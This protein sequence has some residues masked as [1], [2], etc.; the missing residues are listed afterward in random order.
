[1]HS[2]V[3]P[4]KH[5]IEELYT[6]ML[7]SPNKAYTPPCTIQLGDCESILFGSGRILFKPKILNLTVRIPKDFDFKFD[8]VL[9]S[10]VNGADIERKLAMNNDDFIYWIYFDYDTPNLVDVVGQIVDAVIREEDN[11]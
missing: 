7:A 3:N 11:R 1:M 8:V 10:L 5:K 4:I 6:N 9:G 2:L